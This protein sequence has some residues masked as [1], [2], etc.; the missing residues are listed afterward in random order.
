MAYCVDSKLS[1]GASLS[2][3]YSQF[4]LDKAVY[5]LDPNTPDEN[6]TLFLRTDE[7]WGLGAGVEYLFSKHRS[8]AVDITYYDLGDGK[9]TVGNPPVFGD[10]QVEYDKNYAIALSIAYAW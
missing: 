2:L 5:N 3:N 10:I 1:I 9:V 6:R 4:N 8:L 7:I